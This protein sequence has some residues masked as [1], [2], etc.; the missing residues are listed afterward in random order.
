VSGAAIAAE[1]AGALREVAREVGDGEFLAFIIRTTGGATTPWGAPGGTTTT[2][3]LPCIDLGFRKITDP[4]SLLERRVRMIM[5]SAEGLTPLVSDKVNVGAREYGVVAVMPVATAGVDLY[6][7]I[8]LEGGRAL[9]GAEGI[10]PPDNLVVSNANDGLSVEG[11]ALRVDI[12][13]LP[14]A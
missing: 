7:E 13:E 1:V 9:D 14:T 6:Y 10:P 11:G 2:Y 4:N 5:I 8:A 12:D 3:Q